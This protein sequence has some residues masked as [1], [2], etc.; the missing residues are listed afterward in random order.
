[1][2]IEVSAHRPG[3][4][5]TQTYAL[6]HHIA[7]Q[8]DIAVL[9]AQLFVRRFIMVERRRFR[10][11]E[12]LEFAREQFHLAGRQVRVRRARR[13][14]PHQASNADAELAAETLGAA[15][16]LFR[17][18][19][20]HDLQQ[21]FTVAQVDENHAAMIAAT[22]HPARDRDFL[23]DEGFLDLAAIVRT[24]ERLGLGIRPRCRMS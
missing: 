18:G 13:P 12:N 21:T 7:T 9:Q 17:I 5:M 14:S 20:E 16:D 4:L 24:H 19:V 15:E 3:H 11:V 1:M 2:L 10:S 6:L 8:V 22:M 23:A